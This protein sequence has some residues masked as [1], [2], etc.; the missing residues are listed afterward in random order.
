MYAFGV[1]DLS[2]EKA[3]LFVY[4][5]SEDHGG[6]G[7]NNVASLLM[8]VLQDLGL[9]IADRCGGRLSIIMDNCGGQNKNKMVLQLALYLVEMKCFKKVE[10]IFYVK[11]H[12]KNVCDRL[13]N[14]L[15]IRYH[16]ANVYTM[17][18]LS[19]VCNAMNDISFSH[20]ANDVFFD[21]DAML[22]MFYSNFKPGTI[23]VNHYFKV[24]CQTPTVMH[25]KI[26]IDADRYETYDH[27]KNNDVD[28]IIMMQQY[29]LLHLKA[30]GM[31]EIKQVELRKK[32]H[33]FVPGPYKDKIFPKPSEDVLNRVKKQK[34]D[35][36]KEAL[37]KK[38]AVGK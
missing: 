4:G 13:F 34:S 21:Y 23:Q 2:H 20:I 33:P 3:K 31:K 19:E 35:K 10:F 28:R 26:S 37:S 32:W 12:T 17:D 8:K 27:K 6:K 25:M 22:D 18:M 24:D 16:K 15:K 5:Y 36:Q 7:G 1:A 30:P 29:R 38:R 11:G 9:L 14:L